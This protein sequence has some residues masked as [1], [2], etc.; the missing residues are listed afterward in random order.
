MNPSKRSTTVVSTAGEQKPEVS[1]K[2]EYVGLDRLVTG[3]GAVASRTMG[4][5][6]KVSDAVYWGKGTWDKIPYSVEVVSST[7]LQCDQD[8]DSLKEAE[9]A[10]FA[11]SLYAVDTR[12]LDAIRAIEDAIMTK[13]YA[14]LFGNDKTG[15]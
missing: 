13:Y 1:R 11:L 14:G 2:E 7:T 12:M 5:N 10:A 6:A 3:K 8:V 9:D 15:K 4:V